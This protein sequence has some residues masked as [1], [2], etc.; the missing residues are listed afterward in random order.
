MYLM[1]ISQTVSK[2]GMF[3]LSDSFENKILYSP[4]GIEKY[5]YKRCSLK[6]QRFK[7]TMRRSNEQYVT[8]SYKIFGF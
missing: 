8:K 4:D 2:M 7:D 5:R 6:C 3:P 1:L